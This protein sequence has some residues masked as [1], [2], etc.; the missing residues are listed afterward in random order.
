MSHCCRTACRSLRASP[1]HRSWTWGDWFA[2][3]NV[4]ELVALLFS[5]AR[6][7]D[8]A[9]QHHCVGGVL[10]RS[11]A[12]LRIWTLVSMVVLRATREV[13]PLGFNSTFLVRRQIG[14]LAASTS[15]CGFVVNQAQ[16]VQE[17]DTRHH[18]AKRH[19]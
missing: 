10:A 17:C 4:V 3:L 16:S 19:G 5:R 7:H 6:K 1:E 18:A 11:I 2:W 13:I 12:A 8:P 14:D 9:S 15:S